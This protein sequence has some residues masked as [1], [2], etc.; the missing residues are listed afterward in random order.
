MVYNE[1]VKM[2]KLSSCSFPMVIDSKIRNFIVPARN[3]YEN[4][5]LLPLIEKLTQYGH[6]IVQS[7]EAKQPDEKDVF[8]NI[9]VML[10]F[11][12]KS[13]NV[14]IGDIKA[15]Y[16]LKISSNDGSKGVDHVSRIDE[17][18]RTRERDRELQ[19]QRNTKRP[20][21]S[22]KNRSPQK[23]NS[24]ST[25]DNDKN[26]PKRDNSK[27]SQYGNMLTG[28]QSKKVVQSKQVEESVTSK[29]NS[30]Q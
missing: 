1:G 27:Q 15:D 2:V 22:S 8:V 19:R 13:H 18:A 4:E 23:Q 6:E 5:A 12:E 7:V 25:K 3:A 29:R 24:S 17:L 16:M 11:I 30:F 26:Q 20:N 10:N 28:F 9:E 21:D 14:Y